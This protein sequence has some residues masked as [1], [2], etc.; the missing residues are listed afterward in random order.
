MTNKKAVALAVFLTLGLIGS[1]FLGLFLFAG[2]FSSTD[3]SGRERIAVLEVYGPIVNTGRGD[4]F[5]GRGATAEELIPLIRKV[6]RDNQYKALVLKIDTPGGSAAGSQSI[7]QELIRFKEESGKPIIATLGDYATSGGYYIASAAD[8]IMAHPATLTGSIGVIIE[9][10]NYEGLYETLGIDFQI[11]KGGEFKDLGHHGRSITEEESRILQH[12]TDTIY[13]QFIA[14]VVE[15]RGMD[16]ETIRDL[17][18][19]EIF[20]GSQAYELNLVDELGNYYDAI[21]RAAT[22]AGLEDPPVDN[23]S[24]SRYSLWYPFLDIGDYLTQD[25]SLLSIFHYLNPLDTIRLIF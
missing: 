11:F 8:R 7:Y 10:G 12:L 19:G 21:H 18:T 9:I 1:L 4:I 24:R 14:D 6:S 23:L 5:S 15:G 22:M 2:F 25:T 13:E 3:I 17:A 20:S 16:E